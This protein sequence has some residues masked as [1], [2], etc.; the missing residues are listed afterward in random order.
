MEVMGTQMFVSLVT[1]ELRLHAFGRNIRGFG[2][3]MNWANLKLNFSA[4]LR[5]EAEQWIRPI[6][7]AIL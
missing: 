6:T 7:P 1:H 5:E 3:G 2:N 4:S